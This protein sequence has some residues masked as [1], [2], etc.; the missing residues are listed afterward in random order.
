M[1][2]T[3]TSPVLSFEAARK[4][5][6]EHSARLHPSG[7]EL[8][9]IINSNGRVL[10]EP[11]TADRDFPPFAR[12]TR[13][14]YAMRSADAA[15][16]PAT[17]NVSGEIRAGAKQEEI[18]EVQAGSAVAIM[19]GA[20]VPSGA[21][22]VVM[23]EY[24][25]RLGNNVVIN[26][27]PECGENIVPAGAEAKRGQRLLSPGRRLDPVSLGLAASLGRNRLLVYAKPRVAILATGDEVVDVDVSPGPSQIR[28]SNAYSLAA[29]VQS[30]GGEPVILPI[31]PDEAERLK[32]LIGEGFES[33]LL[34]ISGGVSMG[35]YDLVEQAL[36]EF[37]AEFLFTGA[38]IQ[39]GKPIVF[40]VAEKAK[41]FFG[42]PGNPV[43]TL[44]TFQLFVEPVLQALAGASPRKLNFYR[45]RL[46]KEVKVKP[47]LKRFLPAM[48]SGEF[49]NASVE[50][51]PWQG[52][53]DMAGAAHANCYLVIPADKGNFAA[54]EWVSILPRA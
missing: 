13:D 6:E 21:D 7:K 29:Q 20:P 19:T 25:E 52:S 48:L 1:A 38:Q 33:D 8:I 45:A 24:T 41:Y 23:V 47:G 3:Q 28:N 26:K 4:L 17:L 40:G 18:L 34:L 50:L 15:R 53:G 43:S 39:P 36:S 37:N 9:G 22:A 44:V 5:V 11:I 49:E 2:S 31:A 14:G 51:V 32:Q 54:G 30:A 35:K 42:L 12:A 46:K 16:I 27:Q 10:A